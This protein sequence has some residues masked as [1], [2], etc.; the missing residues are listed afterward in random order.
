M[1]LLFSEAA[2]MKLWRWIRLIYYGVPFLVLLNLGSLVA[3]LADLTDWR[4][5]ERLEIYLRSQAEQLETI[6]ESLC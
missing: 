3:I 6:I 4:W 2:L 1:P 5:A